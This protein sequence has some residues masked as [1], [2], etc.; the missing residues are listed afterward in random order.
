MTK[1]LPFELDRS[2][3]TSLAEQIR[4]GIS[5]AIDN[6]ALAPGARLPSWRDL[7][8][9]LGVARGTVRTAY[10][11]LTDAQLIVSSK[12]AGTHVAQRPVKTK[13]PP[14]GP[15]D[16]GSILGILFR[17]FTRGPAL[18]QMGVP[19]ADC[20]PTK[21]FARIRAHTVRA[22][23]ASPASY[24]DPRGEGILRREIAAHLAIARGVTCSPA[25][26]LVTAGF[27][28]ALGLA[29][30]ALGLE[31]RTAWMEDPGFPLTR[32]GLEV[33]R[34]A[35]VPI[36]VDD[37]GLD[38]GYGLQ[39]APD[40]ALAM[41]TPGQQA[42]LGST[43]SLE[44]R[45]RLLA[46]AARTGAWIIEDDYL[47]ELQLKGRAAP[48]LASL[49]TAGRV[50]HIGSFSKTI[51]A[52]LR[53]GFLVVP[54]A[55]VERFTEVAACLAPAPGP[56]VQLATAEFMREGHY[57]RHLR[58]TKRVY[59]GRR[60][61]LKA[62]L[63]ARRMDAVSTGLAI[64]LR[65]PNGARDTDIAREATAYGLAPV[66]LSPWYMSPEW[67]RSGLLL[68]VATTPDEGLAQACA[69]L[70]GLVERFA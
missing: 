3:K 5:A 19:A 67:S 50:I 10:E 25:Q 42:P 54:S 35:P 7:A 23:T 8:V 6:G 44:R 58:R 17:D 45:V 11:R 2:A 43:L 4:R 30:H 57:M 63:E 16:R 26:I 12:S 53:L 46:W 21:L 49:D 40:A 59:A 37:R 51:S 48:A 29:L 13:A 34:L 60:D 9:Q 15:P 32:R 28:G 64:V 66:P 55:L 52:T 69:R 41:V 18:F 31:G 27:T 62:C 65:L 1:P 39:H 36:P 14:E 20:F 70:H 24:P 38:V 61:A 47:G 33:A 68:G 56:S 22:E